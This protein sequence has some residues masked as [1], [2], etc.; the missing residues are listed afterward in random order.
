MALPLPKPRRA[1]LF[2]RFYRLALLVAVV[3]SASVMATTL[4][5]RQHN[6]FIFDGVRMGVMYNR[7]LTQPDLAEMADEARASLDRLRDNT[8]ARLEGRPVLEPLVSIEFRHPPTLQQGDEGILLL[9]VRCRRCPETSIEFTFTTN[10]M[11]VIPKLT[12][13][14][15]LQPDIEF[16]LPV[17]VSSDAVGSKRIVISATLQPS[18]TALATGAAVIQITPPT[19]IFG[20]S[21]PTLRAIGTM[22]SSVGLPA[23][24]LLGVGALLSRKKAE[25]AS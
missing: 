23:L 13:P 19:T 16:E 20:I 10:G 4:A 14:I 15:A 7:D 17:F 8:T 18:R 5:L 1:R 11:H 21:E 12:G 22:A 9:S 2:S 6:P 25:K 24:L 3:C